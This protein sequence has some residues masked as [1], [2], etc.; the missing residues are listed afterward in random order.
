MS[1]PKQRSFT[2]Y[3]YA[4][5][6]EQWWRLYPE[7]FDLLG[8]YIAGLTNGLYVEAKRKVYHNKPIGRIT[9]ARIW[10]YVQ[11]LNDT[12]YGAP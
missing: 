3:R 8:H 7:S 10:G 6:L 9:K 11:A 4:L 2:E 5:D 12:D 1:K